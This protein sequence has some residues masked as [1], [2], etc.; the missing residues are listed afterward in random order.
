M[1]IEAA[2]PLDCLDGTRDAGAGPHGPKQKRTLASPVTAL[3]AGPQ[4]Q[5]QTAERSSVPV[6]VIRKAR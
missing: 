2:L 4:T 3:L 6:D 1:S 5:E